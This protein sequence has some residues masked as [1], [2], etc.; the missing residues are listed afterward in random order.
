MSMLTSAVGCLPVT[1]T[2][3]GAK[4]D[5]DD[6]ARQIRE[7]EAQ[8]AQIAR[9]EAEAKRIDSVE[10]LTANLGSPVG[11][12][13]V[14]TPSSD[15]QGNMSRP[16]PITIGFFQG[17]LADVVSYAKTLNQFYHGMNVK[18]I[19]PEPV[20]T[21]PKRGQSQVKFDLHGSY[22]WG[23]PPE[24]RGRLLTQWLQTDLANDFRSVQATIS[25]T[26]NAVTL[27]LR[28]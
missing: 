2:R 12:W 9:A 7:L 4:G 1:N 8:R 23:V 14:T 21:Y 19:T 3:F 6:L 20:G 25:G 18:K 16:S 17:H 13:H 10:K 22:K 5:A 15:G 11:L 24:Q 28:V 27:D 26:L